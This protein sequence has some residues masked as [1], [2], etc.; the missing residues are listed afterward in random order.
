MTNYFKKLVAGFDET[1]ND[2][3]KNAIYN[4]LIRFEK[5]ADPRVVCYDMDL[6]VALYKCALTPCQ[7][8]YALN[9]I[10][11]IIDDDY[12]GGD[13]ILFNFE[14]FIIM[15]DFLHE[16]D[17]KLFDSLCR[18]V[19]Y[20]FMDSFEESLRPKRHHIVPLDS[21]S[22][23]RNLKKAVEI[24]KSTGMEEMESYKLACKLS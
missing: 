16:D 5:E 21:E 11:G 8:S 9:H 22:C 7:R 23:K 14:E 24:V 10:S 17:V 4:D 6:Y 18:A 20:Y 2:A 15:K 3:V 12:Y 13:H 1:N 19:L